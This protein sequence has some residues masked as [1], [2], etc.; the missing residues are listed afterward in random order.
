MPNVVLIAT[1]NACLHGIWGHATAQLPDPVV[2]SA[3]IGTTA[4]VALVPAF[5]QLGVIHCPGRQTSAS[6]CNQRS[7]N[8]HHEVPHSYL[9]SGGCC[10]PSVGKRGPN[11]RLRAILWQ[12]FRVLS[13]VDAIFSR[14]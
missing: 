5:Y 9:Q 13:R 1:K 12:G 10:S 2:E 8:Q 3:R 7:H 6:E 4:Q 14:G 11:E